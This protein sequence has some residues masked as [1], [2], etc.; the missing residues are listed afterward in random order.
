MSRPGDYELHAAPDAQNVVVI[1]DVITEDEFG[2][3]ARYEAVNRAREL[4][5]TEGRVEVVKVDR[6]G[7]EGEEMFEA[8]EELDPWEADDDATVEVTS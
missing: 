4:S 2:D 7:Y 5:R 3:G 8:G 6:Y 1:L